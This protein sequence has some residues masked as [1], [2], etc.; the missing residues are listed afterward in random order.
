MVASNAGPS[1]DSDAHVIQLTG[2]LDL[3]AVPNLTR[4]LDSAAEA[5]QITVV[6]DLSQVTFIDC[7]G[8]AP[9]LA[10]RDRLDGRLRLRNPSQP[11]LRFLDLLG[12]SSL[13]T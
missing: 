5:E 1:R 4:L 10:A 6:V 3:A 2:E 9:L 8:L 7:T 13:A 12:L 11:V